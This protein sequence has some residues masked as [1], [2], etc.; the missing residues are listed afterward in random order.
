M[1]TT[2]S[3]RTPAK[4]IASCAS[5]R[6]EAPSPYQ[7]TATRF[8]S[9]IRNA[10]AHPTATGSIAGRWLTIASRPRFESAMW[11]LPARPWVGPS[12]RPMYWA[13]IRQGSTPRVTRRAAGEG[14]A[15]GPVAFVRQKR[16][17]IK[18]DIRFYADE[19]E[20]EELFRINARSFLDTGG[21]RYDVAAA[22]G[23]AIGVLHHQLKPLVRST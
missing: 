6:A 16:M 5:P 3:W 22:E 11:T 13:K 10:S 18:E 7:P 8:S 12:D 17:A 20:Q 23:S 1:N 21:A 14:P 9:R 2:G 4:F 19:G 15:G